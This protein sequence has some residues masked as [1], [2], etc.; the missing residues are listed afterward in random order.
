MHPSLNRQVVGMIIFDEVSKQFATGQS[1]LDGISFHIKPQEIVVIEGPSGS[2]K[3]TVFNLI[4]KELEPNKGEIIVDGQKLRGLKQGQIAQLRR[5]VGFAF[6]D[7][8]IIADRT[9][10]ENIALI[11]EIMGYKDEVIKER[12]RHLLKLVGLEN[13]G[14]LFPRQLSGGELQRV[15]IARA[16]AHEPKILLADEPTGNLDPV[17][18]RKIAEIL[19]QINKLGTTVVIATHDPEVIKHLK[20]RQIKISDG[21]IISEDDRKGQ[22]GKDEIDKDNR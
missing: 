9:I 7:F 13:K 15:S 21:K 3:T 19:E 16:I 11:L 14:E 12:V 22:K 18:S 8:K 17:T 1:V 5:K 6:Q 20:C 10:W 2:G 4:Y